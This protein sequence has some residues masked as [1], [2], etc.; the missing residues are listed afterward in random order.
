MVLGDD[1][2]LASTT[3]GSGWTCAFG[4]KVFQPKSGVYD[5]EIKL[6]QYDTSNSCACFVGAPLPACV[7]WFESDCV[8]C[9]MHVACRQHRVRCCAFVL[10][11]L[12]SHFAEYAHRSHRLPALVRFLTARC[13]C[14]SRPCTCVVAYSGSPGW[15]LV[16]GTG[17]ITSGSMP[18]NFGLSV[19]LSVCLPVCSLVSH[20]LS[21]LGWVRYQPGLRA[22]RSSG[23]PPRHRR[24][25]HHLL[26]GKPT[27]THARAC[28]P[29]SEW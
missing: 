1:G 15:A 16:T 28:M 29:V 19:R 26:Q 12:G 17:Q 21:G 2:R 7:G 23:H 9:V 3:V 4:N 22:G 13:R 14:R 27:P 25:H 18:V 20:L 8:L 10:Q 11:Q 5:W 6:D 24:R